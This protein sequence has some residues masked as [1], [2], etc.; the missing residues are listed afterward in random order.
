[1]AIDCFP[2][3][4]KGW[5]ERVRTRYQAEAAL[6]GTRKVWS[7]RLGNCQNIVA[8]EQKYP[9]LTFWRYIPL[10]RPYIYIY[11]YIYPL[12]WTLYMVGTSRF[13]KWPLNVSSHEETETR[14]ELGE[15]EASMKG[16]SWG[17]L[18]HGGSSSHHGFH[19]VSLCS[20]KW[21]SMNDLDDLGYAPWISKPP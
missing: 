9:Y 8:D 12:T 4:P 3:I 21:S 6:K 5:M 1:M 17:F 11:I 13:L 7:G 14:T 18:S 16:N 19:M 15:S 2:M 10:L 20:L